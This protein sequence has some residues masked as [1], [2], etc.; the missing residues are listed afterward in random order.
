MVGVEPEI[1]TP[2]LGFEP[3]SPFGQGISNPP[4]YLSATPAY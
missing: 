3:R 2:G 1:N 4:Q